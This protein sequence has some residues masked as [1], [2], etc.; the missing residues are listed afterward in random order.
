MAYKIP[1][2]PLTVNVWRFGSGPPVGPAI[3]SPCQLTPGRRAIQPYQLAPAG[4]QVPAMEYLILPMG[5]DI[6]DFKAPA[7]PD[8]CEVPANSG[9]FYDVAFVDD[10]GA[11]FLNE[12]RFAMITGIPV[13]PLP[14]P[15]SA[16][17]YPI[18]AQNMS[19]GGSLGVPVL[20]LGFTTFAVPAGLIVL[21]VALYDDPTPLQAVWNGLP[22]TLQITSPM[23]TAVGHTCIVYQ[24]TIVNPGGAGTCGISFTAGVP[25]GVF[26][27]QCQLVRPAVG[28]PDVLASNAG[29]AVITQ[30][31]PPANVVA[32]EGFLAAFG[33]IGWFGATGFGPPYVN[34]GSDVT[35]VIGV[36]SCTLACGYFTSDVLGVYQST[37]PFGGPWGFTGVIGS[38]F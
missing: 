4:T 34:T 33:L 3:V 19:S 2:F 1:I 16:N 25:V 27:Y 31:T 5:T 12:H 29:V 15:R 14:Y 11:G 9:R 17:A 28:T 23:V 6:R 18:F 38:Y 37:M 24:F 21:T 36:Q 8:L 20:A 13:W 22:M 7:G 26:Q 32:V 35:D 10:I 30:V